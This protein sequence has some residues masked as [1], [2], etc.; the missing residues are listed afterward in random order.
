MA[1]EINV[2]EL[3]RR[4]CDF[5]SLKLDDTNYVIWSSKIQ[6]LLKGNHLLGYID[7]SVPCPA[8]TADSYQTWVDNDMAILNML[9]A[10]ISEDAYT[11]IMTCTNS[12]DAWDILQ[13]RYASISEANVMQLKT[14]LQT[15]QKGADDIETYLSK[16]K[17]AR[18][19]LSSAKIQVSDK[20]ILLITLNGLPVEY[21]HFKSHIRARPV[22]ITLAELRT[23]L[24]AEEQDIAVAASHSNPPVL[25]AMM[26]K[27][28]EVPVHQSNQQ[29]LNSSPDGGHWHNNQ[30]GY[31][32]SSNWH[33]GSS[34][35]NNRGHHS[36]GNR[37][38]RGGQN[39][40]YNG[41]RYN[42]R[43]HGGRFNN[44]G[45]FNGGY[46]PFQDHNSNYNGAGFY[47]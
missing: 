17:T 1:P 20:D 41:G 7:G 15:I 5:M 42:N 19:R 4:V 3:L 21:N 35:W 32:G 14:N 38:Y 25:T 30:G 39:R 26:A 2:M 29:S 23:L 44:R 47:H 28:T 36:G 8:R 27:S 34:H 40:N 33:N 24:L 13:D 45:N 11:E 9:I 12:K 46:N 6:H 10:T 18:Q 37:N 31:N 43:F 22:S 16:I